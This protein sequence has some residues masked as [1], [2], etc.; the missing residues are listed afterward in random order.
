MFKK[1]TAWLRLIVVQLEKQFGNFGSSK[2]RG[3]IRLNCDAI[4]D[5]IKYCIDVRV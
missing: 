2:N 4:L 5:Q 3:A 1:I